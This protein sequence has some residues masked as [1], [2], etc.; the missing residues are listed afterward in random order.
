MAH[1]KDA[2]A[3]ILDDVFLIMQN[4][5]SK[6]YVGGTDKSEHLE[7][8]EEFAKLGKTLVGADRVSFWR[9]DKAGKKLITTVAMGEKNN[10]TM[11]ESEGL[12]GRAIREK[13]TIVAN[14]P[15]NEPGFNASMDAKT[16]YVTKSVLVM[17]VKNCRGEIIGAFQAVNKLEERGFDE[18]EDVKRLSIAA[19]ICGMALES[20]IFLNESRHDKLTGLKN[21]FGFYGDCK[22]KYAKAMQAEKNRLLSLIICDIDYFKKVNDT[23]GHDGGDAVLKYVAEILREKTEGF[24]VYRWGGEE[25]LILLAGQNIDAAKAKAEEIRRAVAERTCRC[26]NEKEKRIY[27]IKCSMSFGCAEALPDSDIDKN[28][29]TADERLYRAK[30]TGRNRVVA[31][32]G[33]ESAKPT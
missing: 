4:L 30:E 3:K 7:V 14:D 27:E 5:Y 28:I 25:F 33:E 12:V 18:E 32:D 11:N 24:D 10:L 22:F 15:Q 1:N 26:E 8:F 13:R 19:F 9:W 16:G 17:P 20:D 23:Y 6:I 21:R 2:S 29:K 31:D